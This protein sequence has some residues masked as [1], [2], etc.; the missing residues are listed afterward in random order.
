MST[1]SATKAKK[2]IAAAL[3]VG[4]LLLCAGPIGADAKKKQKEVARAVKSD[5]QYVKCQVCQEVAKNLN[6]EANAVREEKG[7]KFKEGDVLDKVEKIC[8]VE[9]V[10]GEW[11]IK[12]DLV[13]DGDEL[14]MKYMDGAFGACNSE[15][16]TMQKA[17][18]DIIGDRDTDIAEALFTDAKMKRAGKGDRSATQLVTND[19]QPRI[20]N[21]RVL[22]NFTHATA[23]TGPSVTIFFFD[24]DVM[25]DVDD[26]DDGEVDLKSTKTIV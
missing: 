13:E 21:P 2:A 6:R 25:T 18:H 8:D 1:S 4:A 20:K 12:H 14:K 19:T 22:L 24:A 9:T 17:C 23:V 11:L 26:D 7:A 10:E 3:L 15:C 16:K 5:L